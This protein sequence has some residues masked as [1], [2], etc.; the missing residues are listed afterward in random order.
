M[1]L[2]YRIAVAGC[3]HETNTFAPGL[4]DLTHFA[5]DWFEGEEAFLAR[6]TGTR[7]SMGGVIDACRER[8]LSLSPGFYTQAVPSGMVTD[9]AFETIANAIAG[10]IDP[11]ADGAVIILHGAMVSVSEPDAEG[12]IV[13]RVR[14]R[15]GRE[16]PIAVTLDLHANP[17]QAMVDDADL[18]VGYDTYP[19][20]DVYERAVEAVGLLHRLAAGEVKPVRVLRHTGLLVAP[21]GMLTD[22]GPFK[23]VMDLAFDWERQ[24]GI[25][26]VTVIGGFPYSDVPDAGMCFIVTADGD[27]AL[28]ERCAHE[29]TSFA[30]SIRDEFAV[31]LVTPADAVALAERQPAGPVVLVEGSDNVGG[32]SPADGTHMLPHLLR[33]SKPSL[34]VLRDAE[35]ARLAAEAG[36]GGVLRAS[37]GGK[38]DGW[39]GEP[40]PIEGRVRLL[41]DGDYTHIGR[42]MTGARARMGLTA[43]VQ[44]GPVTIVLTSGRVAPWDPGHVLSVGLQPTDFHMIVV[45][46][47]LAWKTA[48]GDVAKLAIDVDTPGCCG[49]NLH[50]FPYRQLKRP[51]YPLDPGGSMR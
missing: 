31:R 38:S 20:V 9:E 43:V 1:S 21:Q 8:G 2:T 25:L 28:A 44:A 41:F 26:N 35:A 13:R 51:I 12:A 48:F 42:Y 50:L 7:T 15:V 40:V 24:P 18:I 6:Y 17:T 23:R 19:H 11:S 45:K 39:H 47:A 37:V 33:A 27:A 29:L 5:N 22:A 32:G 3:V 46:S 49:A 34:L 14:E 4:T 30:W 36:I 16:L 10:S